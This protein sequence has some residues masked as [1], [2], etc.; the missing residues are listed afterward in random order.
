MKQH[1][2]IE[3][4]YRVN[5]G[6][7]REALKESVLIVGEQW[8]NNGSHGLRYNFA[9]KTLSNNRASKAELSLA[10]S[11]SRIGVLDRYIV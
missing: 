11:H 7:Y 9:Q 10:M 6:V 3:S 1:K 5:Y 2:A 8:K 4:G